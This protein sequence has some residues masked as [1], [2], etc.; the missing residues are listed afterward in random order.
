MTWC[1]V[2][3]VRKKL[4]DRVNAMTYKEYK[5]YTGW[6]READKNGYEIE[7]LVHDEGTAYIATDPLT[8]EGAGWFQE[9]SGML[10]F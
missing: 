1:S 10:T 9:T 4:A 3:V 6:R 5:N 7:V 8:G 2:I